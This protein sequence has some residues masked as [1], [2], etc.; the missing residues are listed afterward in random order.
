MCQPGMLLEREWRGSCEPN[1]AHQ[2]QGSRRA[3]M[4]S[5]SCDKNADR[6]RPTWFNDADEVAALGEYQ[7][8]TDESE[9]CDMEYER[10][11]CQNL[12][13]STCK[14]TAGCSYSGG[15]RR[16]LKLRY[17]LARGPQELFRTFKENAF[18]CESYM[19]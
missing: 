10:L 12:D 18:P 11:T 13:E 7:W 17:V 6:H 9:M 1:L 16:G 15:A 3:P 2:L 4:S 14:G 8:P 5:P 19:S